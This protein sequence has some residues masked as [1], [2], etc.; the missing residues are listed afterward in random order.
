[1]A[2]KSI[3]SKLPAGYPRPKAPKVPSFQKVKSMRFKGL[4]K[5]TLPKWKPIKTTFK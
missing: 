5:I 1:M 4:P 3:Y 2:K